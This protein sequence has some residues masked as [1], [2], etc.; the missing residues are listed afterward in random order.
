MS[1]PNNN[2][3][4]IILILVGMAIFSIQDAL[5]KFVFEDTALYELYFGRTL[6]ALILLLL[7]L[8]F[9]NQK[10]I[11]KAHYPYLAVFRVCLLYTS[12]SPRDAT[13]SRMPSSA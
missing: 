8:K 6:T 4:G 2:P 11:L 12:P 10:L 5:I 1:T 3:K 7:F 13:L 9:T